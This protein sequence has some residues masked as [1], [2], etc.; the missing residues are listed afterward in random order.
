M[1]KSSR[2][3][4]RRGHERHVF[5]AQTEHRGE[6]ALAE[7]NRVVSVDRSFGPRFGARGEQHRDRI[8][9]ADRRLGRR[10]VG[11]EGVGETC[12]DR[13]VALAFEHDG[14]P[15]NQLRAQLGDHPGEVG[16][17][18]TPGYE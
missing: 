18:E 6:R 16:V 4:D 11:G 10:P 12:A 2:M 1:H 13:Q 17:A 5:R 15:G 7:Q 14:A 3:R 8:V 9:G